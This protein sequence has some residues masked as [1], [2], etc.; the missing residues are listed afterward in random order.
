MGRAGGILF[1]LIFWYFCIKTKVRK[2]KKITF[3][4]FFEELLIA[5][6]P[7]GCTLLSRH[8]FSRTPINHPTIRHEAR[9]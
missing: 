3:D 2:E 6:L 9:A 8:L 5:S 4:N 7:Q 1:A